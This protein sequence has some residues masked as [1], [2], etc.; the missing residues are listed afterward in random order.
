MAVLWMKAVMLQGQALEWLHSSDSGDSGKT[1]RDQRNTCIMYTLR[2]QFICHSLLKVLNIVK[3]IFIC[4]LISIVKEQ[5]HWSW[6]EPLYCRK[7]HFQVFIKW[8]ISCQPSSFLSLISHPH[9][10]EG[11]SLCP[12]T[13]L[14]MMVKIILFKSAAC[15]YQLVPIFF[16]STPTLQGQTK[17]L[18]NTREVGNKVLIQENTY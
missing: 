17:W 13:H 9:F 7:W 14:L 5:L 4:K 18:Q 11:R 15:A 8:K 12:L 2:Q 10:W 6:L 1:E 3:N 16:H